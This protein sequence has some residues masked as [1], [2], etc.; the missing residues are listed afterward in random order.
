MIKLESNI[1]SIKKK[2]LLEIAG[3][4]KRV[5][6]SKHTDIDGLL[7]RVNDVET[8]IKTSISGLHNTIEEVAEK[9]VTS[10]IHTEMS[11]LLKRVNDVETDIKTS[12][13]GLHNTIEEVAEKRVTSTIHTEMSGLLKRVNDVETD[14]KTSISGLHNTIEER[15]TNTKVENRLKSMEAKLSYMTNQ[16]E[17][18]R[19]DI[20]EKHTTTHNMVL[21]T[22]EKITNHPVI[23][24]L[25]SRMDTIEASIDRLMSTLSGLSSVPIIQKRVSGSS[26]TNVENEPIQ[27]GAIHRISSH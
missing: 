3:I 26:S 14:I 8:D 22:D 1:N 5:S 4:N 11:G 2:T 15:T 18:H 19:D 7:K 25:S 10:T 27:F 24:M 21:H 16:F 17:M 9:R 20:N 6:N 13:S 23:K 12:I